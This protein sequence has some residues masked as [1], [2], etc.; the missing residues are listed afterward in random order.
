MNSYT[1]TFASWNKVAKLYNDKF[2]KLDI[3]NYT[4]DAFCTEVH[5]ENPTILEIGC[6]PGNIT[7]Y[8]LKKRPD[9]IL[10]G[11]DVAPNMIELAKSNNPSAHFS[12]MDC[13]SINTIKNQFNGI[14]CGFC[15]PYLS[16]EDGI[17]LL[18][19]CNHL[20][21]NNGTIYL[22]FVEGDY[23]QSGFKKGSSGDRM[24]FYY[25]NLNQLKQWFL[26]AGYSISNIFKVNYEKNDAGL[27][28]HTVVIAKKTK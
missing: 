22:S 28:V 5:E 7:Q 15:L 16:E 17:K 1:E 2:M 23:A 14:V 13:R 8:L 12:V 25:H 3:Y 19:D 9:F 24:Y 20:L 4:Y 18:E 10:E 21:A 6:G 26:Q 27:E 11:I